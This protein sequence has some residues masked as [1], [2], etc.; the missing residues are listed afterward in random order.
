M[1]L[2]AVLTSLLHDQSSLSHKSS[3]ASVVLR[4]SSLLLRFENATYFRLEMRCDVL[5][6]SSVPH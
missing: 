4:S 1:C 5:V 3:F 2:P 6:S